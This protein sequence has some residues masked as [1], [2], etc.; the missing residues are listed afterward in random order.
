MLKDH[1]RDLFELGD[2]KSVQGAEIA[3]RFNIGDIYEGD[4][5]IRVYSAQG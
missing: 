5:M 4:Y 2:E 3:S 1:Y